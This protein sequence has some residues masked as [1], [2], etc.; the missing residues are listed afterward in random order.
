M[1]SRIRAQSRRDGSSCQE[2]SSQKRHLDNHMYFKY[3]TFRSRTGDLESI[4]DTSPLLTMN[5]EKRHQ[6]RRREGTGRQLGDDYVE[7]T[8]LP[9]YPP[10][11]RIPSFYPERK[12]RTPEISAQLA[13]DIN[14]SLAHQGF[15][16]P[17][18]R[19][20]LLLLGFDPSSKRYY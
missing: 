6:A 13:D 3:S 19:R 7:T 18:A 17:P 4:E 1:A 15:F 11:L 8:P 5:A 12:R 16:V 20:L 10:T 2:Y 14:E 9:R